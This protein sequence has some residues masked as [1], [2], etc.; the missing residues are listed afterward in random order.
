MSFDLNRLITVDQLIKLKN[1]IKPN[2]FLIRGW[3]GLSLSLQFADEPI[4]SRGHASSFSGYSAVHSPRSIFNFVQTKPEA[5]NA[6]LATYL[7]HFKW[8][9]YYFDNWVIVNS[10][11]A[12]Y[13]CFNSDVSQAPLTSC[14]LAKNKSLTSSGNSGSLRILWTSSL[15]SSIR[16]WSALSITNTIASAAL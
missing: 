6:L 9:G 11:W 10:I 13:F 7:S 3:K 5:L 2:N 15:T 8:L 16:S 1:S 14:L 12:T 4:Q